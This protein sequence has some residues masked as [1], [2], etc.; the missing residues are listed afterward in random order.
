MLI[1]HAITLSQLF[2]C[3]TTHVKNHCFKTAE[4]D[5]RLKEKQLEDQQ[6]TIR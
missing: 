2:F 6:L 1:C 3:N 4:D 5:V